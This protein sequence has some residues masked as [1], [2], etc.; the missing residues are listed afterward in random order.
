MSVFQVD[1]FQTDAVQ[2]EAPAAVTAFQPDAF[3]RD[4][5]Q[6]IDPVVG[7]GT[8]AFQ[9]DAFQADPAFQTTSLAVTVTITADITLNLVAVV[10]RGKRNKNWPRIG[11]TPNHD[12]DYE[13]WR[14]TK[15][16]RRAA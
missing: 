16:L 10:G 9:P 6:V 12:R 1:A 5:V 2:A 7:E 8:T 14:V 4:A 13:R 11:P 3:Q 15:P